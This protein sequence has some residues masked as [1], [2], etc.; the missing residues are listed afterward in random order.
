MMSL[1]FN[2]IAAL[3]AAVALTACGGGGGDSNEP[4]AATP[5]AAP[6]Q[7]TGPSPAASNPASTQ[8]TVTAKT[9]TATNYREVLA[10]TQYAAN[11]LRINLELSSRLLERAPGTSN[12]TTSG[13]LTITAT[14]RD[15]SG[16]F[17]VGD[18]YYIDASD[19]VGDETF[20]WSG[21]MNGSVRADVSA[22]GALGTDDYG[23][24]ATYESMRTIFFGLNR[25]GGKYQLSSGA[26]GSTHTMNR[27]TASNWEAILGGGT[28][29]LWLEGSAG[30]ES[31]STR[32][33]ALTTV[34]TI[35]AIQNSQIAT[36]TSG[37]FSIKKS[38]FGKPLD[39]L[40]VNIERD[41]V[42]SA[43]GSAQP[44][45]DGLITV[46]AADGSKAQ[47]EYFTDNT[48]AVQAQTRLDT[49]GDGTYETAESDRAISF[50]R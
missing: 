31:F 14:D 13:S 21:S 26:A 25:E 12:C 5:S 41:L 6:S 34:K 39:N 18:N 16:G 37:A 45:S 20:G 49:D 40:S 28:F 42:E 4:A 23:Y 9:L 46:T 27:T 2:H 35:F 10:D 19:C 33:I 8:P 22:F 11:A 24:T 38:V 7:P 30:A 47:V 1:R 3:M 44:F 17:S 36:T 48:G 32:D 15:N 50:R 43:I 29:S